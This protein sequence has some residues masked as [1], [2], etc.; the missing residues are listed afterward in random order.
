MIYQGRRKKICISSRPVDSAVGKSNQNQTDLDEA[1]GRDD[2]G[3]LDERPAVGPLPEQRPHERDALQRLAQPH[4]VR[5]DAAKVLLDA[6]PRHAVVHEGHALALVE[7]VLSPHCN[8]CR[9]SVVVYKPA[10]VILHFSFVL[11]GKDVRL[12]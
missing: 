1:A 6:P 12:P 7:V 9:L 2:D 10:S 5:H 4:L 11:K 3:L 8:L